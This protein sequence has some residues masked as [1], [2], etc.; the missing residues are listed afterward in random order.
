MK[1]A[2]TQLT[3]LP[4]AQASLRE[5]IPQAIG[6]RRFSSFGTTWWAM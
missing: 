4:V 2:F 1:D 3:T 5:L 6:G